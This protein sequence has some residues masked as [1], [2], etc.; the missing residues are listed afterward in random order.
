MNNDN[1][2]EKE[3]YINKLYDMINESDNIYQYIATKLME[4]IK[5][6]QSVIKGGEFC[7]EIG[8]SASSLS[9]FATTIKFQNIKEMFY[10]HNSIVAHKNKKPLKNTDQQIVK[11]AELISKANKILFIGISGAVGIN[12]DFHIKL[13]RMNKNSIFVCDKYEQVGLSKLL[14]F[15]DLIIVNSTSLQHKW[16]IDILKKTNA[17][18]ILISSRLPEPIKDKVTFYFELENEQKFDAMRIFITEGRV[19]AARILHTLFIEMQKN[20]QNQKFLE[21]SSYR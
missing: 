14:T 5:N 1:M 20:P 18:V 4:R 19:E 6:K 16:M 9:N 17:K 12:F 21:I 13:L 10:I 8:V 15:N 2:Y 11:A 7:T 3:D